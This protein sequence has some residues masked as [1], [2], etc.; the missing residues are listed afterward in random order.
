MKARK[1]LVHGAQAAAWLLDESLDRVPRR[2]EGRWYRYGDWGC[3]LGLSRFWARE[4]SA[5]E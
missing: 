4:D 1:W 5:N 2:E 3:Q